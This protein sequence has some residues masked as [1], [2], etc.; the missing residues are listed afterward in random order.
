MVY[1]GS[2]YDLSVCESILQAR[3]VFLPDDWS[4]DRGVREHL[5]MFLDCA[6]FKSLV[7]KIMIV[8]DPVL[9]LMECLFVMKYSKLNC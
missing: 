2:E 5:Q 7:Y 4:W 1:T 9:V 8:V 3:S 6:Y